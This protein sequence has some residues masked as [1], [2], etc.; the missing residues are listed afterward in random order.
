MPSVVIFSSPN[1]RKIPRDPPVDPV[2]ADTYFCLLTTA[3]FILVP[4][5]TRIKTERNGGSGDENGHVSWRAED[6]LL[7]IM[8][9]LFSSILVRQKH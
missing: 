4:S 9:T 8:L 6:G 2:D 1:A 3:C 5:F 7:Y